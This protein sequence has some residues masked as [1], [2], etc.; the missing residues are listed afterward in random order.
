MS[1]PAQDP[2]DLVPDLLT[3]VRVSDARLARELLGSDLRGLAMLLSVASARAAAD[4]RD[5]RTAPTMLYALN[6][7]TGYAVVLEDPTSQAHKQASLLA[8]AGWMRTR[9]ITRGAMA[10]WGWAAPPDSPF[11]EP[12]LDPRR[13]TVLMVFAGQQSGL[14]HGRRAT[15]SGGPG[16]G[17]PRLDW[18]DV[19]TEPPAGPYGDA[20]CLGLGLMLNDGHDDELRPLSPCPCGSRLK[21]TACCHPSRNDTCP[22]GSL[23]KYKRCCGR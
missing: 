6:A 14:F 13:E 7:D 22:C 23:L 4:S 12:R 16:D 17:R 9:R 3:A 15:M 10:L 8:L 21:I 19:T 1:D 11:A 20:L 5:G 18:T 2:G